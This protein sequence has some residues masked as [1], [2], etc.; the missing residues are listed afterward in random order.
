MHKG[1]P[2]KRLLHWAG[3]AFVLH[4]LWEIGQ[5]S[6]YRLPPDTGFRVYAVLHCTLGDVLIATVTFAGTAALMRSWHWPIRAPWRGG[7]PMVTAGVLYTGFSE[8]HH[9]YRVAHWAYSP[10]MPLIAGV[11][12]MPLLQ[13]LMV[14]ALMVFIFH[15]RWAG[16]RH[17]E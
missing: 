7:V 9:V 11:G 8:W 2:L 17:A 14:P 4:L 3:L 13:W 10:A 12:L 5:L 6:F 16:R 1:T 15:K